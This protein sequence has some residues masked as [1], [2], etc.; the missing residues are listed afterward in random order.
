MFV[1]KCSMTVF[2]AAFMLT[3]CVESTNADS[4]YFTT[5]LLAQ[6]CGNIDPGG[7]RLD[8]IRQSSRLFTVAT[9][10]HGVFIIVYADLVD[11]ENR[12]D[13]RGV[14]GN[15]PNFVFHMNGSEEPRLVYRNQADEM[16]NRI[17]VEET[18]A[19]LFIQA[20]A[21][22]GLIRG[23]QP[24]TTFKWTGHEFIRVSMPAQ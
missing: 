3:V 20:Y 6:V 19:G 9:E 8:A 21:H 23:P 1:Q 13:I 7:N 2:A 5:S 15:G 11:Q 17:A 24:P 18:G 4:D 14:G 16:Q 10:R 12:Y 22:V